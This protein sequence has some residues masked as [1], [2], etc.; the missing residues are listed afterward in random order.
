MAQIGSSG[1]PTDRQIAELLALDPDEAVNL[2][3]KLSKPPNDFA[4]EF[5]GH[6]PNYLRDEWSVLMKE[7]GLGTWLGKGF[8]AEKHGEYLGHGYNIYSNN[9]KIHRQLEFAW[10]FENSELDECPAL[11]MYYRAFTNWAGKRDLIDEIRMVAPGIFL[12]LFHTREAVPHFTRP[13]SER[14]A[15]GFFLLESK[16]LLG[17]PI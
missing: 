5:R 15:V 1:Q 8:L 16:T 13:G 10:S 3:R 9:G 7:S 12:G 14:S 2:F 17:D 4:G 6:V 11:I